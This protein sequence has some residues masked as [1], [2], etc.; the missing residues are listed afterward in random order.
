M[1]STQSR[2]S[3]RL[4]HHLPGFRL[5]LDL[6]LFALTLSLASAYAQISDP[7]A[8]YPKDRVIGPIDEQTWV[9]VPGNIHLHA[10]PEFDAGP[11]APEQPMRGIIIS[12]RRDPEQRAALDAFSAAVQNPRSPQYHKWLTPENFGT[13][14]GVSQNDLDRVK[15]W[16]QSKGFTIGDVPAGHWTITF[17]GT[18][19]RVEAAFRTPIRNYRLDNQLYYANASDPQVPKALA[20]IV[21]G[22]AGLNNFPPHRPPSAVA[23]RYEANGQYFLEPSDFATI[24][25]VNPVYQNNLYAKGINIAVIEECTMDMTLALTYWSMEGIQQEGWWFANYGNAPTCTTQSSMQ[26]AYLDYEWAGAIAQQAQIWLVSSGDADALLGAVTGVVNSGVGQN[27]ITGSSFAPV[28]TMSY[29]AC[30]DPQNQSYAEMWSSLWQQAHVSGITAMV[31]SGDIGAAGCDAG[32]PPGQT[33]AVNGLSINAYC[34]SPYAVCVGGTQFNDTADPSMYWSAAGHALGYIPELAWNQT[35]AN[36]GTGLWGAS[37]GG[38]ST[39]TPKGSWQTGN[40]SQW[41]GAPDVALTA[42]SPHDGYRLCD[43][44]SSDCNETEYQAIGGTS[45]AAPSF[46]GIMALLV[47]QNGP[48]GSVNQTLY[49]LAARN[50]VGLIFHDITSGNNT[51]PGQTGYNAGP[52]WDPVTGLGSVDANALIT[53]WSKAFAPEVS[54]SETSISF[55]NQAV[56]TASAGQTVTLTDQALAPNLSG[57]LAPLTVSNVTLTGNNAGDFAVSTTCQSATLAAAANCQITVKFIP[58]AN[59]TRTAAISIYDN[60]PNSPQTIALSGTAGTSAGSS[61]VTVTSIPN[62]VYQQAPD[63]EGY[64]WFYTIT[65]TETAG[66]ATNLT[67]FSIGGQDYSSDI[68]SWFGS[69]TLPANGTLSA[70]LGTSGLTVPMSVI[71]TA[72]GHDPSGAQWTAQTTV[73]FLGASSSTVLTVAGGSLPPGLADASY[74]AAL[75]ASGGLA[76]YTWTLTGGSLPSGLSLNSTGAMAGIPSAAGSSSFTLQAT[77]STGATGSATFQLTVNAA[78]GGVLSR[79][80]VCAQVASGA[81]WTTTLTVVNTDTAPIQVQVNFWGD[82][83][84]ALPLS[85]TF[86]QNGGGPATTGAS[87]TRSLP[88]GGSLIIN[89]TGSSSLSVGWAE[90]LASGQAGA[91]SIFTEQGS[92]SYSS[93]G[94]AALDTHNQSMFMVPYDNTGGYVTSMSIVN[95]SP[96]QAVNVTATI[97]DE[98]GVVLAASQPISPLPANGH[99]AFTLPAE[100]TT[101]QNHRGVIQFQSSTG[102]ITGLALGFSPLNTF[103]SIPVLYP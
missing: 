17:S 94:T 34:E 5:S 18:A 71:Y 41:R 8:V 74:Y 26:E 7:L 101:S 75:S 31:S 3:R 97:L 48:Q 66:I 77:D 33:E 54:L 64:E 24:Y 93:E 23:P 47:G 88:L 49:A 13:H 73:N 39:F 52:G 65:L 16:L 51:V 98:N 30:S 11:T 42:S 28:I 36:G 87:V 25:D 80:G 103:T 99:T 22:F 43:D 68:V 76:P 27:G 70:P 50:D 62:P 32:D 78:P 2:D 9:R 10:R 91:F 58:T 55:A 1:S 92:G 37:G 100:F 21:H 45:A 38:Y 86:P 60:A 59:G 102:D 84:Q 61:H 69:S 6:W 79:V 89:I 12:L 82:N 95:N 44:T 56:G 4:R 35:A 83:G 46:A 67:S 40:T 53:N 29:G 81:G 19:G 14:F 85:L 15:A 72:G 20:G 63:A 57:S 96:T 90:V